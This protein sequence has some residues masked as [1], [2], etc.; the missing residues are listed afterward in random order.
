MTL[1]GVLCIVAVYK[2]VMN[3]RRDIWLQIF[4]LAFLGSSPRMMKRARGV[5]CF[6]R[7]SLNLTWARELLVGD[8]GGKVTGNDVSKSSV[9]TRC[10]PLKPD[11]D[12]FRSFSNIICVSGSIWL[13][14]LHNVL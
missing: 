6:L 11:W 9:I 14:R 13:S 4:H 5:F 10:V 1:I 7:L 8:S 3:W 12:S 2:S